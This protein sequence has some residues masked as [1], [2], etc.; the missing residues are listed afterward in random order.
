M[1]IA[2]ASGKG[3][4]G[5]TSIAISLALAACS[6]SLWL[7]DCDVEAPNLHFFLPTASPQIESVGISMPKVEK[8]LCNGCDLC[9]QHCEYKAIATFNKKA[10]VFPDLCHAC[11]LCSYICPE[12]AITEYNHPIG[13]LRQSTIGHI[14]LVQGCLD[15]GSSLSVPIIKKVKEKALASS[16]LVIVDCPP[17]TSCTMIHSVKDTEAVVLVSDSTP[18]GL[19]DLKLALS[20]LKSFYSGYISVI[21]NRYDQK[22]DQTEAYC[23]EENLPVLLKIPDDQDIARAYARG[24]PMVQVKASYHDDFKILLDKLIRKVKS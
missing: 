24:V 2:V 6:D 7:L 20:T 11:G 12:K 16:A 17:G 9:T 23:Q 19:H 14:R 13:T 5:K 3:G 18:F 10:V 22:H 8:T 1:K 15:I 4:T 21:I